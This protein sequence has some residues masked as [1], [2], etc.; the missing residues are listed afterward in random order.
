MF[1]FTTFFPPEYRAVL[2]DDVESYGRIEQATDDDIIWR[3]HFTCS[4]TKTTQT[5]SDVL[6][7]H[8]NNGYA[9]ASQGYVI[10]QYIACLVKINN[11]PRTSAVLTLGL[12]NT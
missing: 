1:M 7:F 6:H 10:V 9:N 2:R 4:I 12:L 3:M 8:N 11:T 5:H